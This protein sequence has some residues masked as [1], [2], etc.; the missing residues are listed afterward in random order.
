MGRTGAKFFKHNQYHKYIDI[1]YHTNLY[2][3]TGLRKFLEPVFAFVQLFCYSA[4]DIPGLTAGNSAS[5]VV[6]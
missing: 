3:K 2:I 4:A 5:L 1:S 6:E